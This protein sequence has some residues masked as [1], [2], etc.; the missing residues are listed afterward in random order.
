METPFERERR[1]AR[2]EQRRQRQ[3]L[4]KYVEARSSLSRQSIRVP[5]KKSLN[6]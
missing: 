3:T 1:L 4:L 5:L 6:K 2:E